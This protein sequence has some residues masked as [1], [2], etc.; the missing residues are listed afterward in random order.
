MERNKQQPHPLPGQHRQEDQDLLDEIVPLPEEEPTKPQRD[1][2]EGR[3]ST[4]R[5]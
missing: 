2:G 5:H 1:K 3:G 4:G